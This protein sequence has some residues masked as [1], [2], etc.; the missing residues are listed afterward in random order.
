MDNV[1]NSLSS[2]SSEL[3]SVLAKVRDARASRADSARSAEDLAAG[4]R[5]LERLTAELK[6]AIEGLPSMDMA[7]VVEL[8]NRLEKGNFTIDSSKLAD[9]MLDFDR[10]DAG[11]SHDEDSL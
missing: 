2:A 4:L 9:K 7:R 5:K 11:K 1:E 10:K 6:T 3:Q 8:N